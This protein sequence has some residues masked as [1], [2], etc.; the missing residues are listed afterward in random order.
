MPSAQLRIA[1]A[2]DARATHP[3]RDQGRVAR[4]ATGLREDAL[5]L[6]HAMHIVRVRLD[7][8][9]DHGL[10]LLAPLLGGV[11]VEDGLTGGGAR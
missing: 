3:A 5:G 7:A 10:A 1:F 8:D 6:D 9:Q 11:G 2:D 4:G